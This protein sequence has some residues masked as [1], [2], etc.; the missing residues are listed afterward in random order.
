MAL[1]AMASPESDLTAASEQL[2]KAKAAVAAGDVQEAKDAY[3][4]FT[5]RWLSAE[6]GIRDASREAYKSIEDE[7]GNVSFAFLQNP[8]DP[9]KVGAALDALITTNQKFVTGGFQRDGGGKAAAPTG[10]VAS[11][12]KLL[13]EAAA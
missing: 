7:M 11:L 10:D 6:D 2:A 13:D 5:E 12:L 9:V 1:P 4:A 8:V 3:D